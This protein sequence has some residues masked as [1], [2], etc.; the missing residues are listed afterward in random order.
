MA[1]VLVGKILKGVMLADDR[2]ALR[3]AL[4]DGEYVVAQIDGDCCSD[5][6]VEGIELPALGFP[7]VVLE[8][9]DLG[10]AVRYVLHEEGVT[11]MYGCQI[12]TS[13]G[14]MVIDYRNES[15]GYYGGNLCWPDESFYGGVYG[16]N[17]S[18]MNWQNV[19]I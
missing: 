7:C 5:S 4:A 2:K 3:F 16:Q 12:K 1:N 13:S 15:N 8:V 6:W 14:D 18:T 10:L 11:A 17:V 19:S 9:N